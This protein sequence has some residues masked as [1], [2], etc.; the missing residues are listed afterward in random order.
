MAS[1]EVTFLA[2]CFSYKGR[3]YNYLDVAHL[4]W[5]ATHTNVSLNSLPA[6][7][8]D[9]ATLKVIFRTSDVLKLSAG[10]KLFPTLRDTA[11]MC[12]RLSDTYGVLAQKTAQIRLDG[13]VVQLQGVGYFVYSGYRFYPNGN[14]TNTDNDT[15]V[16]SLYE[17]SIVR[18]GNPFELIIKHPSHSL[19]D[20]IKSRLTEHRIS[21][22]VD[23][24]IFCFLLEHIFHIDIPKYFVTP[25]R[26]FL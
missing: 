18:S 2:Q 10:A 1:D 20:R 4:S 14:L 13:Y 7:S 3:A 23:Q 16:C 22:Q 12:S 17:D 11:G 8:Y 26:H 25:K 24:D 6:G 5:H 21:L 9:E 19:L 15:K